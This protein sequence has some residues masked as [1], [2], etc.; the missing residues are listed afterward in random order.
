MGIVKKTWAFPPKY[1]KN[2]S[3]PSFFLQDV[4]C[5]YS[6]YRSGKICPSDDS[7]RTNVNRPI[8]KVR[9][10]TKYTFFP[11]LSFL[12]V[13]RLQESLSGQHSQN[14]KRGCLCPDCR[15]LF[16]FYEYSDFSKMVNVGCAKSG[17]ACGV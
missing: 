8:G 17:I 1:L 3:H 13:R 7:M 9:Y 10:P 5:H 11:D 2:K 12:L 14:F 16:Q 15:S 4:Q 6:P